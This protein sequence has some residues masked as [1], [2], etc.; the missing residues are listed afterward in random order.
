MAQGRAEDLT[1]ASAFRRAHFF[2]RMIHLFSL[3]SPQ[4]NISE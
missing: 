4:R 3:T 1:G 2:D